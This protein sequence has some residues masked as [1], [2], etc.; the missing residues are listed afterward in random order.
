MQWTR[1]DQ[2]FA[3]RVHRY[4]SDDALNRTDFNAQRSKIQIQS[5]FHLLTYSEELFTSTLTR[6]PR[7]GRNE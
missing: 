6:P 2:Y 7:D 1:M 4:V 5:Y 3:V